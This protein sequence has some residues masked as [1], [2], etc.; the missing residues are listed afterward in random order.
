MSYS[1]LGV[2]I[3]WH[4]SCICVSLCFHDMVI[5]ENKT[6]GL[7]NYACPVYGDPSDHNVGKIFRL[8]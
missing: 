5:K 4:S 1:D 6:F 7:I 3:K 2:S 8:S